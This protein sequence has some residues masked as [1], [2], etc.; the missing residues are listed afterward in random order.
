[1]L[2]PN[3]DIDAV[4]HMMPLSV[5]HKQLETVEEYSDDPHGWVD[6]PR[7]GQRMFWSQVDS[8]QLWRSYF[9]IIKV[10]LYMLMDKNNLGLWV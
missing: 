4:D 1:M 10:S 5:K 7:L 9:I 8:V 6:Q 2:R 3:H